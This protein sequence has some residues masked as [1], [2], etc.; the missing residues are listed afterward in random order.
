VFR[1]FAIL[2]YLRRISFLISL[3]LPLPPFSVLDFL[4]LEFASVL[5]NIEKGEMTGSQPKLDLKWNKKTPEDVYAGCV[6]LTL[7]KGRGLAL[8]LNRI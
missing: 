2:E 4:S 7:K 8:N 1:H 6:G 3:I 5:Y